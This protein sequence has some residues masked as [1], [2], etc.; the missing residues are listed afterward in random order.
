MK[1][2]LFASDRI[3]KKIKEKHRLDWVTVLAVWQSFHGTTL[4]D[5]REEHKSDPA[6]QWFVHKELKIVFIESKELTNVCIL[7][8][9][10]AANKEEKR[11]YNKYGV[12]L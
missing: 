4:E 2:R 8:S 7:K 9:A 11:I 3:K 1:Q 6:T 5:D 12:S 10:F